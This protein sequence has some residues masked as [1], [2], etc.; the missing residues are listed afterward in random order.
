MGSADG[1]KSIHPDRLEYAGRN[2]YPN[3][4][5]FSRH[6]T[7]QRP[8]SPLWPRCHWRPSGK[9]TLFGFVSSVAQL[10]ALLVAPPSEKAPA[11]P[12]MHEAY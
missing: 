7:K 2:D 3:G 8:R 5:A 4:E 6:A 11:L 12:L 1:A 10:Q 9:D